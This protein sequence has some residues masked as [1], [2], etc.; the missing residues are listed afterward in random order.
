MTPLHA[1][2]IRQAAHAGSAGGPGGPGLAR[3]SPLYG[4]ALPQV[5]ARVPLGSP[6]P[7]VRLSYLLASPSEMFFSFFF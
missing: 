1:R 5:P 2:L 7:R 3:G 6:L 4:Q